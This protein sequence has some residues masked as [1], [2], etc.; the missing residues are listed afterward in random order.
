LEAVR[1]MIRALLTSLRKQSDRDSQAD[2]PFG[3]EEQAL[4][5]S[6]VV[7]KLVEHEVAE[8]PRECARTESR[9]VHATSEPNGQHENVRRREEE[10]RAGEDDDLLSDE[11]L[12]RVGIEVVG[13]PRAEASSEGCK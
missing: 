11:R 10:A 1:R 9:D 4:F 2:N 3:R 13:E 5:D 6:Q 8:A 12:D 7:L